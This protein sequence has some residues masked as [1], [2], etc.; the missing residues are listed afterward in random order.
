[1]LKHHSFSLS[2][3][4]SELESSITEMKGPNDTNSSVLEKSQ[5]LPNVSDAT[6]YN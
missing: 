2:T 6:R 5:W 3:I 1:M 4:L